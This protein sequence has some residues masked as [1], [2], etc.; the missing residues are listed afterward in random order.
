MIGSRE[1]VKANSINVDD[2]LCRPAMKQVRSTFGKALYSLLNDFS[3]RGPI[4]PSQYVRENMVFDEKLGIHVNF[5]LHQRL[6]IASTMPPPPMPLKARSRK[7]R[8]GSGRQRFNP[9]GAGL[10]GDAYPI[11]YVTEDGQLCYVTNMMDPV[12]SYIFGPFIE[13]ALILIVTTNVMSV[14]ILIRPGHEF[15]R[16][17]VQLSHAG[18]EI[19]YH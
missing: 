8:R 18:G 12:V 4:P 16:D 13:H 1:T 5:D 7:S 15:R 11:Q 10:Q 14:F 2:V 9:L 6:F 17:C 3:G 19:R